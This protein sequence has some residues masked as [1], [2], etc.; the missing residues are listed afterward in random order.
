MDL[1]LYSLQVPLPEDIRKLKDHGDFSQ[2]Q[3]II[4]RR[5]EADLPTILRERLELEKVI[6]ER[7]KREYPYD[8]AAALDA[9]K[10]VFAPAD[11][12]DLE[13]LKNQDAADWFYIDGQVHFKNNFID[14]VAKTRKTWEQRIIDKANYQDAEGNFSMLDEAMHEMKEREELAYRMTV[15][16]SLQVNPDAYTPDEDLAVYLPLPVEYAQVHDLEIEAISPEPQLINP[17]LQPQR[18]VYFK[19]KY[20]QEQV[21]K[22]RFSFTNKMR[23]HEVDP[24]KVAVRQ[25][26]FYTQ[27]EPPHITFTPFIK[28][29]TE[30]V[31]GSETNPYLKAR[32]IYDFVTTK[33]I[34]SFMR[35][36]ITMTHIPE[37]CISSRKGD[38]GV[39]ALTF[40]TM[41]RYA[42]IP[43]RWQS[44]LYANPRSIG[45]HDWAQYYI[46]PYGWLY[47]DC[48]FGGSAYRA[49]NSERWDFYSR[50][51][52]P[53]RIP[54]A[55]AFQYPLNP[56][57]KH[58]RNDPYDNQNGE[59]EYESRGLWKDHVTTRS[60]MIDIHKLD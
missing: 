20:P 54:F 45:N 5:L 42:G 50:N 51:L 24:A 8:E 7:I 12:A 6:L 56:V 2:A 27:E 26:N 43:A 55:S 41:C 18:S 59:A 60:Q 21:F 9:L 35:P 58:L 47:A 15:E 17:P 1:T 29:V 36:Y 28:A 33:I 52:E 11:R 53:F 13:E 30:E 48:S 34:Y 31:V 46:E 39:L 37:Y 49:G 25:P 19:G 57:K 3:A 16:M 14:N 4:D 40:I 32:K 44:G 22:V 38:C 23:Y 10:K